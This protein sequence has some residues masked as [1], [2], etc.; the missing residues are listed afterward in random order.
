MEFEFDGLSRE[1][2]ICIISDVGR[3]IIADD[4]GGIV[5]VDG[6]TCCAMVTCS[7][8]ALLSEKSTFETLSSV[9]FVFLCLDY[10]CPQGIPT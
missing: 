9:F 1:V 4:V 10:C 2:W 8:T 5:F 3:L 6:G 7:S